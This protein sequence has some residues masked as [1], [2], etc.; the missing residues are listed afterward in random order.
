[1]GDYGGYRRAPGVVGYG[2]GGEP[3]MHQARVGKTIYQIC[4]PR[5]TKNAPQGLAGRETGLMFAGLEMARSGVST[6]LRTVLETDRFLN[7]NRAL[8]PPGRGRKPRL[9]DGWPSGGKRYSHH[10][11]RQPA[12]SKSPARRQ[13]PRVPCSALHDH[14][15]IA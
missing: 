3:V 2:A 11:K 8:I 4:W 7:A 5:P 12:A 15:P 1:V 13:R 14:W 6:P 9:S 10:T